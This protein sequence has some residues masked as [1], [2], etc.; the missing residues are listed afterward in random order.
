[1]DRVLAFHAGGRR[2]DSHRGHMS[3]QFFRSNRP[4]YPHPVS[5]VH[6]VLVIRLGDLSLPRKSVVRLTDRPDMTLDVYRGRNITT[7]TIARMI[8]KGTS[9]I[10]KQHAKA[11]KQLIIL[12]LSIISKKQ[13]NNHSFMLTNF[14]ML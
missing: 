8:K 4:G 14:R 5:S 13:I 10:D 6:E 3:E 9:N 1:M 2:F 12:I 11:F 7:T